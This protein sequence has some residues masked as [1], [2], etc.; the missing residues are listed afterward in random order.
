[1]NAPRSDLPLSLVAERRRL[2]RELAKHA[3]PAL[4]GPLR[5][6]LG[7]PLPVLAVA[8][9]EVHRIAADFRR[10]NR[11][12]NST[13]LRPL[14]AVLW[15]GKTFE[16]RILAIA[17]LD[18][19]VEAQDDA[20]WRLASSWVDAATGWALSDSLAS[21]PVARMVAADPHRW[22]ELR[23]WGRSENIWRRRA[24][25]YALHDLVF[26]GDLDRPFAHLE[27]LV[28]D[29]EFWVRRA[30]GTWLR[31]CWKKDPDRTERFLRR[32][33]GALAPLTLTVATEQASKSLRAELRTQARDHALKRRSG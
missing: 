9:P 13:Q 14:L 31:E 21:G 1:V 28:G 20:A 10:R 25:T 7:S 27:Q 15:S 32:H 4:A 19:F 17:I 22:S 29:P 8:S 11:P 18:R 33:V 6:Y 30:V 12:L 16:E 2:R 26:A 3:R 24:S 23:E 5:S